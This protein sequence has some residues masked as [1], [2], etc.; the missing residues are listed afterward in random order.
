MC[1]AFSC[2]V[3]SLGK[4]TWKLG[5]DS[6]SDLAQLGG[7]KDKVLGEFAKAEITPKN[8]DYLNP[9]IWEFHWDDSPVPKWCGAKEKELCLAA[10]KK[11]LKALDRKSVV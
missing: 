7:Y 3:D 4:V 6:H 10:H 5:I 2:I 8:N 11:W 9:D 1:K